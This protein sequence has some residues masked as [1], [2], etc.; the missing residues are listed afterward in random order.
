MKVLID[1]NVILDAVIGRTPHNVSAEKLFLLMAEDK[2][3]A[4]IT[5]SAVTDIY[6]LLYKHLYDAY[7]AKQVLFKLFSLFEVLDVTQSDCAKALSMPMNDYED[8]LLA[9]CARRRKLD[10]IITRNLKDFTD[11]PVKAIT[12]D[13]F[14]TNYF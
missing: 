11:S 4:S 5:A 2:L 14:L 9:T 1:T 7:Q 12:P 13:D 3:N 8:A 10:L 6:Y